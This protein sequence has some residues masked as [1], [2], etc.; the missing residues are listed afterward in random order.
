MSDTFESVVK[1]FEEA[2]VV[3]HLDKESKMAWAMLPTSVGTWNTYVGVEEGTLQVVA[4]HPLQV[5][6]DKRAA[7]AEFI[8]RVGPRNN[9]VRLEMDYDAGRLTA[10]SRLYFD[11][12]CGADEEVVPGP[13]VAA[14]IALDSVHPAVM[15]ILHQG[16]TAAE[17]AKI[18]E[19]KPRP[20]L[21]HADRFN[22][23]A[24]DGEVPWDELPDDKLSN[25]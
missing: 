12:E 4:C 22:L 13:I 24:P 3:Y 1:H 19:D 6:K 25:N 17:A 9:M 2:E 8:V 7:I 16:K 23:P 15:S 20:D 11:E 14:V 10:R 18:L 21:P 5:P